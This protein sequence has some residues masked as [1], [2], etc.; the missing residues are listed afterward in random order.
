MVWCRTYGLFC[1]TFLLVARCLVLA[2]DD[3]QCLKD[4]KASVENKVLG[5]KLQNF[6]LSGDF[7]SGLAQC[8]ALQDLDLSQNAFTGSVPSDL[9]KQVP[10]ITSLDLSQN[11][12]SGSIPSTL[13]DCQYLQSLK[14][15][16]NKF[17][18]ELPGGIAILSKLTTIDV[19]SNLLSGPIP[20]T[21]TRSSPDAFPASA[22]DGNP[23]LCGPPSTNSCSSKSNTGLIIGI[24]ISAVAVVAILCAVSVWLVL[25]RSRKR[26]LSLLKDEDKWAK[27]IKAPK[28]IAVSLFERP[29]VIMKFSDLFAATNGFSKD[30]IIG[31]GSSGT[32]FKAT[33]VDG[34][35]LAV[36]RLQPT[37]LS[38]KDFQAEMETLGKLRHK[39]LVPLLG[40]CSAGT[41]RL[42]I[43]KHMVSGSL[44]ECLHG[45]NGE[46][47][48]D[49][50][51]RLKI[52]IGSACGL[53]WLH[54]SCNP[55]IIHRNISSNS[56]L[57]DEEYEPKIS[58]FGL[59]RLMNP[60]DTHI[61]T[62]VDGGFGDLGYVAPEYARTLVATLKGDVYSFGVVLLEL[63][64]GQKANDVST[65]HGFKGNL[66]EWVSF[67]RSHGRVEEVL[68]MTLKGAGFDD[69][70]NQ[71]LRVGFAC[72]GVNSKERPSMFEVYQLLVPIGKKFNIT[73]D[74]SAAY[75]DIDTPSEADELIVAKNG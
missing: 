56:I 13:Q 43:Y 68:D 12:F 52:A 20:S 74:E 15:Q 55:R 11:M 67:L 54:H 4:F 60:V 9:C 48:P 32:V 44:R 26:Q 29:L 45:P 41:E 63:A 14:L 61:S 27:R 33:L 53:A 30:N 28:S 38:N 40:Y 51:T 22:F 18:G 6:G 7:P 70:L 71:F 69:E 57:L 34:S 16:Q 8:K 31:R 42:L 75:V 47:K 58:D 25:I 59:A 62:V 24:S 50:T 21:F 39:N 36:K 49:W 19:S 2:E 5:L 66:V 37:S 10:Y 73:D 72:T 35:L 65:D 64:T 23:G 17:S 3:S 46:N 1:V